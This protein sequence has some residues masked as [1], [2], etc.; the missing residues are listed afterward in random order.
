MTDTDTLKPP[1]QP[2]VLPR[3]LKVYDLPAD[4]SA[5]VRLPTVRAHLGQVASSTIWAWIQRGEF[6]AP[7]KIGPRISCWTA[8]QVRAKARLIAAEGRQQAA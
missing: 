2:Q 6:P 5:L 3:A 1:R 7:V 4:D 8:G